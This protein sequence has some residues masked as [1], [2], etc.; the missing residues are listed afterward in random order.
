MTFKQYWKLIC[1]FYMEKIYMDSLYF[2]KQSLKQHIQ[3]NEE[4]SI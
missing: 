3:L 2:E 4:D 1:Q